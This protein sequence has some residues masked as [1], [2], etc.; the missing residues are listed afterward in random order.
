MGYDQ[1]YE[2]TADY[3]GKE[4]DDILMAYVDRIDRFARVLDIGAGQGRNALPVARLGYTVEAIDV[5]T[6][7]VKILSEAARNETLPLRAICCGFETFIPESTFSAILMFGM[8]PEQSRE[9]TRLM[10][11]K[12]D[13]W[14]N[15]GGLVFATAFTTGDPAFDEHSETWKTIGENSFADREG[16]IRTYLRSGELLSMFPGWGTLHYWEGMGPEHRHGNRPPERHAKAEGVFRKPKSE[17]EDL[18]RAAAERKV[19]TST[20]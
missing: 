17:T 9:S 20:R 18:I 4:P 5:S 3:F 8:I 19:E 6:I 16:T 14:T 12:I 11:A 15:P 13:Q 7:A 1:A 10:L 2:E